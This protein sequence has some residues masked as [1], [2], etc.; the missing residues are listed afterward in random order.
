MADANASIEERMVY[1]NYPATKNKWFADIPLDLI[2]PD[3]R[4]ITLPLQEFTIPRIE[5]GTARI[6]YGGSTI[7]IPNRTFN[8]GNKT[9]RFTYLI[10]GRWES[11]LNLYQWAGC[12]S[13]VDNPTQSSPVEQRTRTDAYWNIPI[14]V[15]L[16]NEKRTEPTVIIKYSNCI[17]KEFGEF[18]LSYKDDPDVMS[19]SFTVAYSRLD[20][21]RGK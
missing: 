4:K 3:F 11:Y 10:D 8:A 19:H 2:S 16:V 12:Y 14:S 18:V 15:Y 7:E 1:L 21:M 6:S 9:I 5:L 17:L 20:I 13:A